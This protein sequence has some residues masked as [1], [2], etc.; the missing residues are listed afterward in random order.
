[1]NSRIGIGA[2]ESATAKSGTEGKMFDINSLLK[3]LSEQRPIFHSEA[4]F[5]H[6]LAWELHK[7][8]PNLNIRLE[9]PI[10]IHDSR[11]YLDILATTPTDSVAIELKYKTRKITVNE[12]KEQFELKNQGAQDIGRYDFIK[13]ICRL[14]QLISIHPHSIGYAILLTNDSAYWTSPNKTNT[15]DRNFKLHNGKILQ[16][17]LDW[18]SAGKGTTKGREK[19]LSLNGKYNLQWQNYSTVKSKNYNCFRYLFVTI[20]PGNKLHF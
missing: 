17:A 7:K 20:T 6:S 18:E 9:Y 10:P 8:L 2:P 13:D 1:M 3:K 14:E 12:N 4:D 16:G 5:Q 19:A 11:V 15:V